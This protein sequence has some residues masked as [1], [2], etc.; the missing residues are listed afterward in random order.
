M[1]LGVFDIVKLTDPTQEKNLILA[2]HIGMY[3]ICELFCL[4]IE[5]MSDINICRINHNFY[6][7]YDAVL[8]IKK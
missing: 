3:G 6:S 5:L 2:V 7:L 4:F 8:C 1:F